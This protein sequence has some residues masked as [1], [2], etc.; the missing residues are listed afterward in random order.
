[1][2]ILHSGGEIDLGAGYHLAAGYPLVPWIGVMAAGYGLGALLV[3]E[4]AE[5]RR[6]LLVLG[7]TATTLFVV[8]RLINVYGDPDPWSS[9]KS[10][11]FTLFSFLNCHKY[12][13]SLL[14][15]LMTLGPA[16][17]VLAWMDKGTPRWIQPIVVFG[18]VPLFYYLLHLP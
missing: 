1:W 5:R 2:K 15:L 4:A 10:T 7:A 3:K 8:L 9:Q 17:L 16:L 6:G 14:Y 18:R 12:P 11:A 13:P